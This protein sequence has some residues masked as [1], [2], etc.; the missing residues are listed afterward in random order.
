MQTAYDTTDRTDR[1]TTFTL[2]LVR[3]LTRSFSFAIEGGQD[4]R[5]ST[6]PAAEYVN[7]RG[8]V[9]LLYS[10]GPLYVPDKKM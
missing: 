3:R 1:D 4:V 8:L 5:R 10:T 2:R 6:D 7:Y 9:S